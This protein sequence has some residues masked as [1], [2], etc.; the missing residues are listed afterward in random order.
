MNRAFLVGM[1]MQLAVLCLP[2]LQAVF[3]T[4]PMTG[5]Q[6]ACVLALAA[7]PVAICELGKA[8]GRSRSREKRPASRSRRRVATTR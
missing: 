8:L 3:D 6:W 7:A 5:E 4:V 1:A 2:P